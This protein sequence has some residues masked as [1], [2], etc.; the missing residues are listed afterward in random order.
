MRQA[1]NASRSSVA[2]SFP[3][4][5]AVASARLLLGM[6]L[7]LESGCASLPRITPAAST[8]ERQS[9]DATC[10]AVFPSPPWSASH[11]ID[12]SLPFGKSA[13]LVG[14]TKV[15]S[16]GI[17]SVLLSPEGMVL[18]DATM[19]RG[20]ISVHRAVS[21][22]DHAGFADG[23]MAD[24]R[25]TFVRPGSTSELVGHAASGRPIC[26]FRGPS[27]EPTAS[28]KVT[29]SGEVSDIELTGPDAV[30]IRNYRGQS[31]VR[32]IDLLGPRTEGFFPDLIIRAPGTMGYTLRLHLID[33]EQAAENPPRSNAP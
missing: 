11:T 5:T 22:F 18:F 12:A 13:F 15:S 21:P 3:R 2:G 4:S 6:L 17:Q 9:L 30:T 33:H 23:L 27:D 14:V 19:Q 28:G 20:A 32:Q 24:V 1:L 26:R 10:G 16:D 8:A 31:L 7:A 29:A 25:N